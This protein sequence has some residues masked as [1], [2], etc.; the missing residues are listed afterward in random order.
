MML[1]GGEEVGHRWLLQSCCCGHRRRSCSLVAVASFVRV[2][3]FRK[4]LRQ[5][6]SGT[7]LPW[8]RL[9]TAQLYLGRNRHANTMP[10]AM[11]L[12]HVAHAIPVR[13]PLLNSELVTAT[14]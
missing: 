14:H 3:G 9:K 1:R 4:H 13:L 8:C 6:D 7:A 5:Y 11:L 12:R 10:A 2:T